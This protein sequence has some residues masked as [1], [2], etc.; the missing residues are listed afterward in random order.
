MTFSPL[1]GPPPPRLCRSYSRPRNRQASAQESRTLVAR[2]TILLLIAALS[3]FLTA[4]HSHAGL[5]WTVAQ[6]EQQYGKPALS[7]EQIAGRL[8]YVFK[9]EDYVIVA[10]FLNR[11]VSRIICICPSDSVFS[12]VRARA[13][14]GANAPDTIW[15]DA[16]K[17]E[18][19][20]PRTNEIPHL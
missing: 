13:L 9:G 7:Q 11:H 16:F 5:G 18:A 4:S 10:F 2:K 8:G 6:F 12:W 17:N 3:L 19:S 20:R 14:L 15:G 1:T